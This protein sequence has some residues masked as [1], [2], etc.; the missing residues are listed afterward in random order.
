[1]VEITVKRGKRE[2]EEIGEKIE[3][4]EEERERK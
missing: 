1:M 2:R 4:A 3:C